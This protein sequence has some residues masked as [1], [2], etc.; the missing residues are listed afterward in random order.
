MN[1]LERNFARI[2]PRPVWMYL[3]E[4]L[5]D[6]SVIGWS[7]CSRRKVKYSVK[8]SA[9]PPTLELT[10]E[11]FTFNPIF[12][13][14]AW[15]NVCVSRT[16]RN[17]PSQFIQYKLLILDKCLGRA[18]KSKQ[19][20]NANT[21]YKTKKENRKQ[22]AHAVSDELCPLTEGGLI[23]VIHYAVKHVIL[24]GSATWM[25]DV[26]LC[27]RLVCWILHRY[28]TALVHLPDHSV[29]YGWFDSYALVSRAR[30]RPGADAADNP[31]SSMSYTSRSSS[32]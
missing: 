23:S 10:G 14:A 18:W 1:T 22:L 21:E 13:W 32:I 2:W 25:D 27:L 9:P 26:C 30:D 6:I 4:F 20:Q 29:R 5:A 24:I 19:S 8:C 16:R 17:N 28:W 12:D 11:C 31:I 7:L 3:S 15:G